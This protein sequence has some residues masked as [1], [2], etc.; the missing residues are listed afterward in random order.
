M[1]M[2]Q[3]HL[4]EVLAQEKLT[5]D[6][7]KWLLKEPSPALGQKDFTQMNESKRYLPAFEP[8]CWILD[9]SAQQS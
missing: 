5:H 8:T 4:N 2:L 9:Y 7:S 6:V 1:L 3:F